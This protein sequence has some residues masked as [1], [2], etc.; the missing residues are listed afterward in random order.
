MFPVHARLEVL[1]KVC[2]SYCHT[3]PKGQV[4]H[5]LYSHKHLPRSRADKAPAQYIDLNSRAH[6]SNC[7]HANHCQKGS[8]KEGQDVLHHM[9]G[10]SSLPDPEEELGFTAWLLKGVL[11]VSI[12]ESESVLAAGTAWLLRG[13]LA[14]SRLDAR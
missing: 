1:N 2:L 13:V 14:V 5:R 9:Q 10:D 6:T 7:S 12:C 11:P 4:T 8:F 3:L